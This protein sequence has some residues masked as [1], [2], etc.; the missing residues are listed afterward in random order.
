MVKIDKRKKYIMVL[1]V[2]T[3]GSVQDNPLVYDLGFLITDKKGNILEKHSYV[4]KEI[5][6]QKELMQSAYYSKKLPIYEKGLK[7]GAFKML[8]LMVVRKILVDT[9]KKWNVKQIS[10]YN[11]NFDLG[12]LNNTV[13]K[14]GHPLKAFFKGQAFK[15][16]EYVDIWTIA[17]QALYIQKSFKKFCVDNGLISPSGNYRTSAEVGYAYITGD[18]SFQEAHTGLDDCIIE[19]QILAKAYRQNKKIH[20]KFSKNGRHTWR[21]VVNHHGKAV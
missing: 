7:S 4:I 13:E 11:L 12:A 16:I 20:S 19:A 17:C 18:P 14:I 3:A 8:P 21:Y 6:E 5:Y 15:K 9:L 2:E 1:D 10:A